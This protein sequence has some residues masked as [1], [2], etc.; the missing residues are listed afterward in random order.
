MQVRPQS[1]PTTGCI[2]VSHPLL[3]QPHFNF[4]YQTVVL[5]CEHSIS[6]GTYGLTLNRLMSSLAAESFEVLDI[7]VTKYPPLSLTQT[8]GPW[9]T[10]MPLNITSC[11]RRSDCR[12]NAC[13]ISHGSL[14]LLLLVEGDKLP[15][16]NL[17][18]SSCPASSSLDV[19]TLPS[20]NESNCKRALHEVCTKHLSTQHQHAVKTIP[21]CQDVVLQT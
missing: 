10:L 17:C 15:V 18:M 3:Y 14:H 2:L 21:K 19:Y 6:G 8:Q 20:C 13:L 4:F 1:L 11:S 12:Q 9:C 5:I 16:H 7:R